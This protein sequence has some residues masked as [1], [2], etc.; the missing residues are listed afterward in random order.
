MNFNFFGWIRDGVRDAVLLG[1]SDAV[2]EI[3]APLEGSERDVNARTIV[4][5]TNLG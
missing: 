2:D 3:G 4:F 5:T 1:V